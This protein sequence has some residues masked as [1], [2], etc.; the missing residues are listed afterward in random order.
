MT[1]NASP[2]IGLAERCQVLKSL[3]CLRYQCTEGNCDETDLNGRHLEE[4]GLPRNEQLQSSR[5]CPERQA[6][7]L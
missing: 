4:N 2:V 7:A 1:N 3:H 6:T 5:P